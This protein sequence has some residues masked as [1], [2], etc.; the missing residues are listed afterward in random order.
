MK[1]ALLFYVAKVR[2]AGSNPVVRSIDALGPAGGFV[3]LTWG[4][5]D[6]LASSLVRA[7]PHSSLPWRPVSPHFVPEIVPGHNPST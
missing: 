5:V 6:N 1:G 2:V 4:F 3:L 7:I